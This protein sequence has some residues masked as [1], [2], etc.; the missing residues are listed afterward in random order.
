MRTGSGTQII[1]A[2]HL[3]R[4]KGERA[5]GRFSMCVPTKPRLN[6]CHRPLCAYLDLDLERTTHRHVR[7]TTTTTTW[8]G[9]LLSCG[10]SGG[11]F[12]VQLWWAVAE[13]CCPSDNTS[14]PPSLSCP[15]NLFHTTAQRWKVKLT[16]RCEVLKREYSVGTWCTP[17]GR[18]A[19]EKEKVNDACN[20]KRFFS[21]TIMTSLKKKEYLKLSQLHFRCISKEA[22]PT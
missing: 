20:V 16:R 2:H 15:A 19:R 6:I 12:S 1:L 4:K 3:V 17:P 8:I 7:T 18:V 21:V 22:H 10:W 14:L 13:N 11:M 9:W 5:G